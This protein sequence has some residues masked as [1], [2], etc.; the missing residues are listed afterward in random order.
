[1]ESVVLDRT[2]TAFD[3]IMIASNDRRTHMLEERLHLIMDWLRINNDKFYFMINE[4][5]MDGFDR[6]TDVDKFYE[7]YAIPENDKVEKLKSESLKA[8]PEKRKKAKNQEELDQVEVFGKHWPNN[9]NFELVN[10]QMLYD[11]KPKV[12]VPGILFAMEII[13][14]NMQTRD[15]LL[16]VFMMIAVI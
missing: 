5:E 15:V 9:Q 4:D 1:M 16:P 12:R 13:K 6:L 10:M 7:Y 3:L 14:K 11:N 8:T 2:L